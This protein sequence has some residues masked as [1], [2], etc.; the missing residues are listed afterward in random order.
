ML[1][2]DFLQRM[3]YGPIGDLAVGGE[4][5]GVIPS[6]HVPKVVAGLNQALL[7][8][9]TR[10]CLRRET[11]ELVTFNGRVS[12]PLQRAFAL[13]SGSAEAQ[14]FIVDSVL[15]PFQGGVLGIE[16]V[17]DS[18]Q[19]QLPLN[20]TGDPYS[21]LTSRHD[22][23]VTGNPVADETY[24]VLYRQRHP[25]IAAAAD[26][27]TTEI[28]LPP[29]LEGALLARAAFQVFSSMSGEGPTLKANELLQLYDQECMASEVTN[30]NNT[31]E[32]DRRAE[33]FRNGGWV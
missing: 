2:Q 3:A 17:L 33:N 15:K 29:A 31:S 24:F 20:V 26:P 28:V 6:P 27:A 1:L 16:A 19:V 14:K 12:Y 18:T 23:L 30:L 13:T 7:A 25:E 32:I 9:H 4:H 5:S 11:L 21:W 22:T 10:F 8:L